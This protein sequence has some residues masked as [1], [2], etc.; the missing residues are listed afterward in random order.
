[1]QHHQ[2]NSFWHGNELSPVEWACLSSFIEHGHKV[3]LF[4]YDAIKAP[5]GI[6]L[7]DASEIISRDELFL[8]DGSLSAFSNIFRYELMSRFGEWWIDTYVYYFK[9][10]IP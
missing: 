6:S 3:R 9:D 7:A 1:M 2:F 10:G 8:F 4:C 5:S